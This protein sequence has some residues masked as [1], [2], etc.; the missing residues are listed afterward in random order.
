MYGYY[1]IKLKK[2]LRPNIS[3]LA[4]GEKNISRPI[5]SLIE[6]CYIIANVGL[7]FGCY[8]RHKMNYDPKFHKKRKT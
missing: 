5:Q 8:S 1:K 6:Y 2:H 4:T 7:Y 3:V